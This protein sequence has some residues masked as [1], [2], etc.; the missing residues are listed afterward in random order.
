[1]DVGCMAA[2]WQH[3]QLLLLLLPSCQVRMAQVSLRLLVFDVCS[4]SAVVSAAYRGY[5]TAAEQQAAK[6]I[7][8]I[9]VLWRPAFI[10]LLKWGIVM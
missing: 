8:G 6:G 2:S 4:C 10:E 7:P 5:N 1:M 3:I 9:R